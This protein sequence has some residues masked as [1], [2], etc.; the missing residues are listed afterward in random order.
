M[1]QKDY[2]CTNSFMK[3]ALQ[4]K[5]LRATSFRLAVYEIFIQNDSA[6]SLNY[7]ESKL[8]NF[9]RITLYRTLKLFKEKGLIHEI[10]FS[11]KEKKFA[12]CQEKCT[13]ANDH[14]HD[15][16]HFHC[17][18]CKEIFCVDAPEFPKINLEGYSIN[19]IEIQAIGTCQNCQ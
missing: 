5:G 3:T 16:I 9:D 17:D 4:N 7:I 12:L 15:H 14:S 1:L 19:K 6:I 8:K 10:T 2:I 13:E 18:Q 11:N